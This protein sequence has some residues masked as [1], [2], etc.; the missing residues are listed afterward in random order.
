[1]NIFNPSQTVN[2]KCHIAYFITPHGFG[3]AARAIAIMFSLHEI[4]P[5]I[6][7]E[8]FTEVPDWF[9][10][11]SLDD[12]FTYHSILCDIGLIQKSSLQ[13]DLATTLKYLYTFLPFDNSQ[14]KNL[15]RVITEDTH[16][17]L[18]IC[19]IAPL[20]I[21]IGD[22]AN[23]PSMLIENFTWDWI[24][25]GYI[26]IEPG[27]LKPIQYL[28]KIFSSPDYHIQIE[29]V[30]K[31]S[32]GIDLISQPVSR[33][34]IIPRQKIREEIGIPGDVEVVLIT[35][36]GIQEHFTFLDNLSKLPN[37]YFI[38]PGSSDTIIKRE[39]MVLLPHHSKYFHPDLINASDAV[40]GKAGYST[41]AEVYHAGIPFGYVTRPNFRESNILAS[42]IQKHN[43]C[44]NIPSE[45]F[46]CGSWIDQLPTL[47]S[48][49]RIIRQNPNG[50][51]QIA[52]FINNIL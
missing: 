49:K 23:I 6:H 27:F 3:H 28:E 41:V 37:I 33:K 42:F 12:F 43:P 4:A 5:S 9:F 46:T 1:M 19:D 38:I 13:E 8:I 18:I 32:T 47:L 31:P 45:K 2:N 29:P 17:S 11:D 20:G 10:E 36:G 22:M 7:F 48:N 26:N 14:I 16:C 25:E 21:A 35:M 50:A 52:N 39:N 34:I 40:V 44:L 51:S 24:Y 15:S 30:C